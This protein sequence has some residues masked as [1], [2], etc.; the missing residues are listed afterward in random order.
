MVAGKFRSAI[1]E[2]EMPCN[3][4]MKH[5]I[6]TGKVAVFIQGNIC[7]RMLGATNNKRRSLSNGIPLKTPLWIGGNE[8]T[9]TQPTKIQIRT[10]PSVYARWTIL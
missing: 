3:A 9:E 4:A 2:F 6:E 10:L 1:Y 8:N 5:N 7:M